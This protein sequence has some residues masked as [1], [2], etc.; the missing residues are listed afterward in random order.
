MPFDK[1]KFIE[2]YKTETREHIQ[3]LNLGLLKLEKIPR[4]KDLLEEMMREAH[5][6]KGSSTM[7]GYKRIADLAHKMED[8]LERGMKGEVILE[9]AHFDILFKCLD[10][11]PHL[12]EDKVTWSDKGIETPFVDNLCIE[13]EDIFNG[14]IPKKPKAETKTAPR[15]VKETI[16]PVAVETPITPSVQVDV[17]VSGDSMRVDVDKLNKIVNLSGELLISKIRLD[18][19]V[20][21]LQS[22]SDFWANAPESARE[23]LRDLVKVDENIDFLARDMQQEVMKVRMIPVA[24]LFN[25]YPRAM[26]DLART[27]GKDIDFVVKG[28]E[29][30]LDKAILDRL[31]DP[32]MHLLRNALD[33]GIESSEERKAYNK[34]EQGKIVL[35]AYQEGSHVVIE[36]S[37]DGGGIDTEK[38]KHEAIKQGLV[39]KDK[40]GDLISEQIFQLLFT[41]GFSTKE[42]V[43]ETSGRG[44]GLDVVREAIG[45]LKGMV[46]V[47][48]ERGKGSSFI[49]RLP[50]TLAITE[51]LLVGAGNDIFAIP[52][53]S[54][55]E[56][57]R[58]NP[59]EIKSVETKDAITIRG[60]ILPLVRL[61]D[62]FGLPR[63]GIIEK[64]HL[65][66]VIV[67]SV[68]KRI[69]LL[70]DELIG[71]Q[72]IISKPIGAPLNN[73][74]NISGATILGS[75]KVILALDIPSIIDSAEGVVIKKATFVP[76]E[77]QKTKKKK[78]ILLAE[79]VLTTAMLEK[80]I[81]ES[82]GY[83]VVI[84]RD[85]KEAL[86]RA[87][88]ESFDLVISDVLM[89]RMDGFELVESLRKEQLY[90]DIPI[91][92]VTTRESDADKRRGLEAGADA[93]ILK[94]EFTS[95]SLLN[96]LERLL[97]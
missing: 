4:N 92:I 42:E 44:V 54:V 71:R 15:K 73:V 91:V 34:S 27:K 97:G 52:V 67:Q 6:I 59:E 11:I 16:A 8:G 61:N 96:T 78:T 53:D 46:E 13:T 32:I 56:T 22:K 7:M 50:L 68:E 1:S 58:V 48:S 81:L 75:G 94:S 95:E 66:V 74:K 24:Y 21:G 62:I 2:T 40:V 31:K 57:L 90:K 93:Y 36:V 39:A 20:K 64:K 28:E 25:A 43:T 85:G 79:D 76:K 47:R 26:R 83:S 17:P 5:T 69:G 18:E 41:P 86:E 30:Q 60:H 45:T 37:D 33:H 87:K 77:E 89:P 82:V 14:K 49:M 84:A 88:Q 23:I 55:V 63:K 38:V 70:V 51:S 65:P 10:S 29:T 9:K 72:D 3:K 12:L 35:A 19:L 80:N